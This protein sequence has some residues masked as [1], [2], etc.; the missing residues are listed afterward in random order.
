LLKG[1]MLSFGV[2]GIDINKPDKPKITEAGGMLLLPGIW[3]LVLLLVNLKLINPLAY[4]FLFTLTC[5]AAIGF[6]DDGFK[7]FK[8]KGWSRYLANRGIVAYVFTLP[9]AFLALPEITGI[10][11]CAIYWYAVAGGALIL[12]CASMSNTFAGLNGW[13][14]GSSAIVLAGLTVMVSF[15]P[16]YTLTLVTLCLLMLGAQLALLWFNRY[17][18]RVFPGDSG[19][20]MTGAFIGCMILFVDKWYIALGLFAPHAYDLLLKFR[21]N[22]HDMSQKAERPYA[23][24]DGKITVPPSGKLDFAKLLVKKLGPMGEKRLV[25]RMHLVVA[26]NTLFWTL[27]YILLKIT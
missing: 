7:L 11:S 27:L 9:F 18:A 14:V 8:R 23:L 16:I 1:K 10:C 15:S 20:L 3:I 24:K 25:K 21:T 13:E 2:G 5:F 22:R 19:T 26:Q 17:P 6:F 4:A 12:A